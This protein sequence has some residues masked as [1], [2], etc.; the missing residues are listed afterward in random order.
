MFLLGEPLVDPGRGHLP[1]QGADPVEHVGEPASLQARAFPVAGVV[2]EEGGRQLTGSLPWARAGAP[3]KAR[4]LAG[5]SP[6]SRAS[7]GAGSTDWTG[8]GSRR[9][10][11]SGRH[12]AVCPV[13]PAAS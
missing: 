10:N 2:E 13:P 3:G 6:T 8:S 1:C 12:T 7:T 4:A 9:V 5:A 11:Q